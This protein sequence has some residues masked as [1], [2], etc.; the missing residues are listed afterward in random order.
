V[1]RGKGVAVHSINCPNVTS[2]MYEPDRKID[3]QWARDKEGSPAAYPV[4]LTLFC[5]DR[6]GM[7]KQI[8]SVISDTNTNIRNI[9]ARTGNGQ[10]NIDVVLEIADLKHLQQIING[11]RQIPGVHDV[12]IAEDLDLFFHRLVSSLR[13][14]IVSLAFPALTCR[15]IV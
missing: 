6:F 12:Q 2:L 1:T 13:D 7:L 5:D 9:E 10:A 11:V 15:A 14:S 4:K 3:V 8:T